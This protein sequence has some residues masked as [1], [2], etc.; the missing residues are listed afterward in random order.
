MADNQ[1]IQVQLQRSTRLHQRREHR[2]V[3]SRNVVLWGMLANLLVA[4]LKA[5]VGLVSGSSALVADAVH[6]LADFMNATVTLGSL[7]LARR[8][9]DASH[10]YGHGRTEGLA[11]VFT[12]VIL[13]SAG[14]M[15]VY[16]AIGTLRSPIHTMPGFEALGVAVVVVVVQHVL[17]T[18]MTKVGTRLSS[19][20]VSALATDSKS[21]VYSASAVIIGDG[22]AHLLHYPQL[23]AIAALIV[24]LLIMTIGARVT[25][26][27][28]LELSDASPALPVY[29]SIRRAVHETPGVRDVLDVDARVIGGDVR[30]RADIEVDPSISVTEGAAI[31]EQVRRSVESTGDEISAVTVQVFPYDDELTAQFDHEAQD[32]TDKKEP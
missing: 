15:V 12:A 7:I 25:M 17:A 26:H 31:A 32:M 27:A 23:D 6:S 4:V 16:E 22:L 28:A 18:M 14:G 24:G 30:V 20:A 1:H 19:Q 2:Y 5:G 10:H 11:A 13:I 29:G 21:D 9:P 3:E 8:P